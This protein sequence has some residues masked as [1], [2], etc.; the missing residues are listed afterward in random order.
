[1]PLFCL[2]YVIE[3][4]CDK[5]YFSLF[6]AL[7]IVNTANLCQVANDRFDNQKNLN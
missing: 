4:T 3:R 1:M 2:T 7:F 6:I 5:L